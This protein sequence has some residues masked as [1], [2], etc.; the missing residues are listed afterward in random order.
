MQIAKGNPE[1]TGVIVRQTLNDLRIEQDA[2]E[3]LF[4]HVSFLDSG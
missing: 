2:A 4:R 1:A 3:M